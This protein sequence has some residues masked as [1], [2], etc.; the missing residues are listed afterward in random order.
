LARRTYQAGSVF[1]KDKARADRWIP[2]A[3]GYGRYWRDLPGD[4]PQRIVISL[5]IC[6]TRSV[7][8]RKLADHLTK[9][10]INS[11]P[12]LVETISNTT[13]RQQGETWLTS[14]ANRK[15][16]PVEQ[17][18]IKNRRYALDK[19]IYPAL[20]SARLADINNRVLKEFVEQMTPT[21]SAASIR[22]YANIVKAVVASDD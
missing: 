18:T 17:T 4:A 11:T 6:P 2:E 21:L 12:H 5:G 14:L 22:D 7:A 20:G 13:F 10:G 16:N 3:T 15:R 1:Q 9:I 19:W 8:Q